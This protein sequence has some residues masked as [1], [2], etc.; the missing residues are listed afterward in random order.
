MVASRAR[1]RNLAT[2]SQK[3][4]SYDPQHPYITCFCLSQQLQTTAVSVWA[5][6]TIGAVIFHLFS[7][8]SKDLEMCCNRS[9]HSKTN[10]ALFLSNS[11]Q[12]LNKLY[13]HKWFVSHFK[14]IYENPFSLNWIQFHVIWILQK[15]RPWKKGFPCAWWASRKYAEEKYF[16]HWHKTHCIC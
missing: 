12:F 16:L 4:D 8:S 2:T 3:E 6:H 1:I 7:L 5:Q 13:T 9:N 14:K 11:P 15:H 10:L